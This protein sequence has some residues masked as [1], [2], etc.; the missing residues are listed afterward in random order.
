SQSACGSDGNPVLPPAKS[1][2]ELAQADGSTLTGGLF[3]IQKLCEVACRRLGF[4]MVQQPEQLPG[5]K[6]QGCAGSASVC[7]APL[8]LDLVLTA[9]AQGKL[10]MIA[11]N[12]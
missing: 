4:S 1:L 5:D 6:A 8:R 7:I 11:Y 10:C 3:S 9:L 12:R 2:L